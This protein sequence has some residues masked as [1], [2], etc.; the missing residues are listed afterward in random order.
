MCTF[1]V[2]T[3]DVSLM[4]YILLYCCYIY[5]TIVTVNCLHILVSGGSRGGS[6]GSMEPPFWLQL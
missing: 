5:I 1:E 2:V 6:K 3:S 4:D